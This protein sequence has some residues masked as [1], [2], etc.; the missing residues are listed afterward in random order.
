M[1]AVVMDEDNVDELMVDTGVV[2]SEKRKFGK[3]E[4]VYLKYQDTVNS[5]SFTQ[6]IYLLC[7][8]EF[9]VIMIYIGDDVSKDDAI[10]VA[11]NIKIT[12]LD[13]TFEGG[14]AGVCMCRFHSDRR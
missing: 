1:S 11:E 7:P 14:R 12:E 6:R 10:K 2:E 13:T 9:R 5:G 3:Y 4:G 8:E